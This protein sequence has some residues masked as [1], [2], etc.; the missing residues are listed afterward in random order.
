MSDDTTQGMPSSESVQ[1]ETQTNQEQN[2]SN[3]TPQDPPKQGATSFYKEQANQYKSQL[4]QFR[5]QN[6]QL[7]KQIED[8]Q[9]KSMQEKEQHKELAEAYKQKWEQEK[10]RIEEFSQFVT[11][12]K[13]MSAIK[14]EAIKQGINPDAMKFLE[15]LNFDTVAVETTDQ[16][17]FHVSGVEAAVEA[18]KLENQ[19]LFTDR[20][21]P[22]I[23]NGQPQNTGNIEYSPSDLL[24]LQK[25]NPK[26]YTRIMMEKIAKSN[27]RN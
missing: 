25:T 27:R 6:E 19:F 7:Q 22:V 11:H 4:E 10:S 18:F 9:F 21:P 26:E 14:T 13:K 1:T 15:N 16:G 23:N 17:N 20:T 8:N 24:K 5:L 3:E 2:A 12:D